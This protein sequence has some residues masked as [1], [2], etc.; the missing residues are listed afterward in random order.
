MASAWLHNQ[1]LTEMR[2]KG[3]ITEYQV[4]K[5]RETIR[6]IACT[7]YEHEKRIIELIFEKGGIRTVSE[8][9]MLHFVRNRID[10]V[11]SY[12]NM[13]PIFGDEPGLVSEWFYNQL[14]SYKYSDFFAAQQIQYVRD[15]AKHKLVFREYMEQY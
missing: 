6:S 8:E 14:S 9:D 13:K 7:V 11:L 15:W 2:Q 5:I 12:L 1:T 4:R 3:I 10:V